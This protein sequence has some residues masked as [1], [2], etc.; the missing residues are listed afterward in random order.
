MFIKRT[1]AGGAIYIQIAKS[2]RDGVSVRHK[3]ILSLGRADKLNKK[4]IDDL[5]SVL[6]KLRE[7]YHDW[8]G[9]R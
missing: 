3:A 1:K 5:I 2:Y 9:G 7:E 8:K 6:L 4:D